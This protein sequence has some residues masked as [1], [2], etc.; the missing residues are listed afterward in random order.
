MSDIYTVRGAAAERKAV[1]GWGWGIRL[2]QVT[3]TFTNALDPLPLPG[4]KHR[5]FPIP[6]VL[7][8]VTGERDSGLA[9]VATA[10][11]PTICF[12]AD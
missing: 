12:P 8:K 11:L 1:V 7:L 10:Y 9:T 3:E 6:C 4:V 5:Q 2:R